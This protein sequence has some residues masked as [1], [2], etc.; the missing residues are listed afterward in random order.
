VDHLVR[1]LVETQTARAGGQWRHDRKSDSAAACLTLMPRSPALVG[2]PRRT[3]KGTSRDGAA[4]PAQTTLMRT[5]AEKR[6]RG[7]W[8]CS[9]VGLSS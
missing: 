7:Q 6:E 1:G 5:E 8:A 2:T 3:A 4:A 9:A